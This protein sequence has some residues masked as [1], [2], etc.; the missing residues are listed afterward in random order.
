[1]PDNAVDIRKSSHA[2]ALQLPSGLA[3]LVLT[4]SVATI[5][6]LCEQNSA[7]SAVAHALPPSQAASVTVLKISPLVLILYPIILALLAYGLCWWSRRGRSGG[8]AESGSYFE[9]LGGERADLA[10]ELEDASSTGDPSVSAFN[11]F[12]GRARKMVLDVRVMGIGMAVGSARMK[13]HI[14]TTTEAAVRQGELAEVVFSASTRMHGA[15]G[16]MTEGARAIAKTTTA[17]LDAAR[18]SYNE[19]L[20][21][22]EKIRGI[23]ERL[24]G[25]SV[26]VQELSLNSKKIREIGILINGI[27]DQTNLLAL[28]AAIEAARAGEVGRGFAVVANEVRKLADRVKSATGVITESTTSMI[29]LVDNTL[30]ETGLIN[31]DSQDARDVVDRSSQHFEKL[32]H[33]FEHMNGELQ[34]I[35]GSIEQLQVNNNFI[36]GRVSEIHSLSTSVSERMRESRDYSGEL[37]QTAERLQGLVAQFKVGDS[38][39]DRIFDITRSYRDRIEAWLQQESNGGADLFDRNYIQIPN[40]DPPKY[41]TVYDERIESRLRTFLDGILSEMQGLRYSFC[42]D[43]NG[44]TPSHNTKFSEPL[45]GNRE[46]DILHNRVKR[47]FDDETGLR[48]ARN[49][50]DPLLQSYLRDT[51]ELLD[52]LSMP[53][54]ISGRHW[55][56]L[57]VGLDPAMLTGQDA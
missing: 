53:I 4:A 2:R 12:L 25:F 30:R 13:N 26:T 46:H 1:M 44:Y 6:L 41:H 52:D 51:G 5:T 9:R 42:V 16:V 11:Q 14:N 31:I 57:R 34:K 17:N 33:E 3:I 43:E 50:G 32:V 18:R 48:A 7:L 10:L 15:M 37:G 20:T 24:S 23:S 28:N 22:T 35:T 45:T 40:S 54:K 39:F 8:M 55:G 29:G 21:A 47:K 49:T 19:L 27:S 56:A 36:H 38:T